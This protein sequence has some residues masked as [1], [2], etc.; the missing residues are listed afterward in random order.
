MK[1]YQKIAIIIYLFTSTMS[2]VCCHLLITG[3]NNQ[4]H[5]LINYQPLFFLSKLLHS[6]NPAK[7]SYPTLTSRSPSELVNIKIMYTF[8]AKEVVFY[9][10][11]YN[12]VLLV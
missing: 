10:F 8:R 2:T 11:H 12:Y 4:P 7:L 3:T 1:L 6:D 5:P 9:Q